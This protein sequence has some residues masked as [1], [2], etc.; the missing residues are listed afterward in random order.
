[1]G[2]TKT[3]KK[4]DC[5]I[6]DPSSKRIFAVNGDGHSTTAIN[7]NHGKVEVVG[8]RGGGPEFSVADGQGSVYVNL[9]ERNQVVR[10]DSNMLTVADHWQT[11]QRTAL[12]N[13]SLDD[14]N[15]RL[16]VGCR[17]ELMAVLDVDNVKVVGN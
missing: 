14:K 2:Q 3:G 4:P 8:P 10:I 11:A 6:Y 15:R 7:P 1:M 9:K 13:L 12:A 16:F 17:S 5:V